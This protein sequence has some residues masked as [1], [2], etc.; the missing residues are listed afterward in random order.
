MFDGIALADLLRQITEDDLREANLRGTTLDA[1]DL[2]GVKLLNID[3]LLETVPST[4]PRSS[5]G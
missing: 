1:A 4:T 2:R 3:A 5:F